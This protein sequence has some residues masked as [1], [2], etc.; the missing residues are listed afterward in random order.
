VL[1]AAALRRSAWTASPPA[2]LSAADAHD[3]IRLATMPALQSAAISSR[4][5]PPLGSHSDE[6][7]KQKTEG[8]RERRERVR[9]KTGAQLS[10]KARRSEAERQEGDCDEGKKQK[11]EGARERRER[12]RKKTGAQ[13]SAKARRSEGKGNCEGAQ[14]RFGCK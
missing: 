11:T 4:S 10:A 7:K 5:Y 6:R 3:V 13:L 2:R 14:E 8:A 1:M 9:K 12:T